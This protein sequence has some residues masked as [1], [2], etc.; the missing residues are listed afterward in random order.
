VV[1]CAYGLIPTLQPAEASF[2][3][4]YAVYGGVFIVLSY[5]WGWAIDKVRPD[6][7]DCVG[8]AISLVGVM[9]CWFW[10]RKAVEAAG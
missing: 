4:V 9:L 5:L 1:L 6:V 8:A 10:P 2:S 3:R 7:G